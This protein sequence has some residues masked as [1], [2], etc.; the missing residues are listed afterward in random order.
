MSKKKKELFVF[1]FDHTLVHV[2]GHVYVVNSKTKKR[3]TISFAEYHSYK[4]KPNEDFDVNEFEKVVNPIKND[5][6]FER[7][8]KVLGKAVIL[9]ARSQAEP[10]KE[11]LNSL[12]INIPVNA[13]GIYIKGKNTNFINADRKKEWIK[14]AILLKDFNHVEFYDDNELNINAVNSLQKGVS[15]CYNRHRTS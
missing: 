6:M 14:K 2:D 4:L 11:Y 1:D 13:I 5:E 8:Q 7:L 15:G 12:G 9:T 3:K 10:V